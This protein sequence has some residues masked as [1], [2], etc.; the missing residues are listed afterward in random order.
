MN[1]RFPFLA[2]GLA[3]ALLAQA[4][5]IR[6]VQDMHFGGLLVDSQGGMV[7]LTFEGVRI[8]MGE[9]V[10]TVLR[11]SCQEAWFQL[12]GP[13]GK[14]FRLRL[15]PER[16]ALA[17]P[18]GRSLRIES[19]FTSL[20]RLE[21]AFDAQGLREVRLGAKLDIPAGSPEGT[22]AIRQVILEMQVL[23]DTQPQVVRQ[24]FAIQASLRPMLKVTNEGPLD[25]GTL[26]PGAVPGLFTVAPEGT[27]R[28]TPTQG[29]RLV[30]GM[31]R[32]AAFTLVGPPGAG[33]SLQLPTHMTMTGPGAPLE[34]RDFTCD[35]PLQGGLP[36]GT[37]PFRVGASLE[38]PPGQASGL[39][40][41]IF[42]ISICYQ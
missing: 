22:Y 17:G 1:L 24:A 6:L 42:S 15:V 14:P 5:D 11:P 29:P 30:R 3:S 2:I 7:T 25:F 28:S 21:G 27:H 12:S 35:L 16:P 34:V 19:F 10:R 23:D 32:P 31:P 8:P 38:V 26:L 41:G 33:Y 13:P 36:A 4:P 18:G 9:G 20:G 39:Y 40:R 37:V